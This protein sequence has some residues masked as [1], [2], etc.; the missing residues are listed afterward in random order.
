MSPET[1]PLAK[2]ASSQ[3]DNASHSLFYASGWINKPIPKPSPPLASRESTPFIPFP[4]YLSAFSNSSYYSA[5]TLTVITFDGL[6]QIS[7]THA[8]FTLTLLS[9]R[10]I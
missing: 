3:K 2:P 8:I 1:L 6:S 9:I 7:F 10:S 5:F 4:S